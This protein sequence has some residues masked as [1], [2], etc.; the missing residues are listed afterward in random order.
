M[1][2][3]MEQEDVQQLRQKY[4]GVNP[5][6]EE[7]L[8]D[9][10]AFDPE[11]DSLPVTNAETN[12]ALKARRYVDSLLSRDHVKI[13]DLSDQASMHLANQRSDGEVLDHGETA[14]KIVD[15][16]SAQF[17]PYE[18]LDEETR[19]N[20]WVKETQERIDPHIGTE[21]WRKIVKDWEGL[22]E[23]IDRLVLPK[24]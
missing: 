14:K 16:T 4:E 8:E 13:N 3:D 9:A 5:S 21:D 10:G 22:E 11:K 18:V 12:Y 15:Y 17:P 6:A 19:R 23:S 1:A 20:K 7:V 24:R 2:F